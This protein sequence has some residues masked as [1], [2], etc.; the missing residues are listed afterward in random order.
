MIAEAEW[1]IEALAGRLVEVS[2]SA[3]T[4]TL[5]AAASLILEAQQPAIRS[6]FHPISRLLG[7]TS[8]R[9]R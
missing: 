2:G 9:Y 5:T 4:A 8:M 3:P 1:R 7:S 6:F